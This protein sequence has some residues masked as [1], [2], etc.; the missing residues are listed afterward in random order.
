LFFPETYYLRDVIA[1]VG[2]PEF[3]VA[4]A[5]IPEHGGPLM[6]Q[7][8]LYNLTKGLSFL[9]RGDELNPEAG[10]WSMGLYA[11][12]TLDSQPYWIWPNKEYVLQWEGF[13]G[14]G[15]Y[16]RDGVEGRACDKAK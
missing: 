14:F 16:C 11:P 10:I 6:S 3:V 8:H 1:Q 15:Y 13:L 12:T 2:E 9:I 5:S 7:I 4:V